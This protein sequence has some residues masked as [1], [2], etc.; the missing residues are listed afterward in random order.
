MVKVIIE[1]NGEVTKVL[2]GD[3]AVGYVLTNKGANDK[4]SSFAIGKSD[5]E[6]I[7][8]AFS[9]TVPKIIENV[10]DDMFEEIGNLILI[11][12]KLQDVINKKLV[13]NI[14]DISSQFKQR[15]LDALGGRKHV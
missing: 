14:D 3:V 6:N 5:A 8:E 13:E 9:S 2:T 11:D 10:S 12:N 15:T 7:A 1:L 4:L